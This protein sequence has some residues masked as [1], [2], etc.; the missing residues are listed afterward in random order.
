[1]SASLNGT[2]RMNAIALAVWRLA[3]QADSD[4]RPPAGRDKQ[5]ACRPRQAGCLSSDYEKAIGSA[6]SPPLGLGAP[7]RGGMCL[8]PRALVRTSLGQRPRKSFPPKRALK[9]RI[10]EMFASVPHIALVEFDAVFA[11]KDAK[12][13]RAVSASE[14]FL[15]KTRRG[16]LVF[17]SRLWRW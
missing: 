4:D 7:Q 1:M 6:N 11:Q 10:K 14:F 9:A 13:N 5:D 16:E 17:I 8:A 12:V 15:T 3:F 2:G